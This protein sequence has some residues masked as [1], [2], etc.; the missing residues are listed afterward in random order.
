M[1]KIGLSLLETY[2]R[3]LSDSLGKPIHCFS[4]IKNYSFLNSQAMRLSPV[5]KERGQEGQKN[6][7]ARKSGVKSAVPRK[8]N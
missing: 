5:L 6:L 8:K 7:K 1:T 2:K 4:V 3:N